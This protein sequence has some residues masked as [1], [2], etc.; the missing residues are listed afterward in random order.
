MEEANIRLFK[1]IRDC[2]GPSPVGLGAANS[3][4]N[5]WTGVS[6]RIQVLA[7][8]AALLSDSADASVLVLPRSPLGWLWCWF[9]HCLSAFS[10]ALACWRQRLRDL[11]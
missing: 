10:R 1:A 2:F 9:H 11:P 3:A 7:D 8:C 5:G 6:C 4:H